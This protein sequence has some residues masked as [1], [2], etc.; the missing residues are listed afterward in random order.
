[1]TSLFD[2]TEQLAI[3]VVGADTADLVT[4]AAIFDH[5]ESIGKAAQTLADEQGRP[6]QSLASGT[7]TLVQ[8]IVMNEVPDAEESL[9]RVSQSAMDLQRMVESAMS[10]G[11]TPPRPAAASEI[12]PATDDG[13]IVEI[14]CNAEDRSLVVDFVEEARAHVD[15]AEAELLKLEEEPDNLETVN[16][17]FRSFHT[18]KGVAGFLNLAQIGKLAHA[19]ESLLDRAREGKL[20]LAGRALDLVLES[21]DA[22]TRLLALLEESIKLGGVMPIWP[23][24]IGLIERLK[25]Y[26]HGGATRP[27]GATTETAA[28]AAA[29]VTE[30]AKPASGEQTV[31]VATDRLDSLINHVGELVIAHSMVAQDVAGLTRGNPRLAGNMSHLGKIARELQELSMAMRMVPI[32]GVFQKMVRLVRD[33]SRKAGK[34]IELVVVGKETELDRN[35]VEAIGDPLIHMIRNACDHG[36]EPPDV[37]MKNGKPRQGR[38]ELKASHQ[39]G[40]IVIE[41]SDDGKGLDSARILKKAIDNGTVAAGQQL[42]EAEIFKLIFTA[43]LSTAEKVTDISGRGVGMDVVK[44]NIES[45]RGRVDITST[46]GKGST[47]TIRLPL[48]LAV[49]DGLVV[50][51]GRQRYI[52]PLLSVEQNIRPTV[53]QMSSVN[54]RA[55][56]C[57]VRGTCLPVY[58]LHRLFNV[59]DAATDP[60]NA[61]LV[62]VQENDRRCCFMVDELLGQ[63]QVVIK[64]LGEGLSKVQGINGGAI[65]GDGNVSLILD[66]AGVMDLALSGV[67]GERSEISGMFTSFTADEKTAA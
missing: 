4:L 19:A 22:M 58:R 49:I 14:G 15:A 34:E 65:L 37:R 47:F 54:G 45:L 23:P 51:V 30:L 20:Q 60:T 67:S 52:L 33:V 63:E 61:I 50:R 53:G 13:G 17:I 5:L 24:V 10:S 43:G 25:D 59:A 21:V 41:I 8:Q 48:T 55:E 29:P 66:I 27:V 31:K 57:T 11:P 6:I 39:S 64:S 7:A 42:S 62:V 3:A 46:P 44:K 2:L 18:I 16:A 28:P 38:I 9:R 36:I 26:L 35:V 32:A 40:N 1:M 12:A 56:M